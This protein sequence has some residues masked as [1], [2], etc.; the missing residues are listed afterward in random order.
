MGKKRREGGGEREQHCPSTVLVSNFPYSFTNS[1]VSFIN[2]VFYLSFGF[3][4]NC[5]VWREVLYLSPFP[6]FLHLMEG[7]NICIFSVGFF[8]SI[9]GKSRVRSWSLVSFILLLGGSV[10]THLVSALFGWLNSTS[11]F[12]CLFLF[13]YNSVGRNIQWCWTNQALFHGNTK[14]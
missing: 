6:F 4:E 8:F 3:C 13:F 14:G 5:R 12:I 11:L 2:L 7:D 9:L 1:Q 10:F